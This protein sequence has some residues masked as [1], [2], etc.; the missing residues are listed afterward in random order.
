[1]KNRELFEMLNEGEHSG[2]RPLVISDKEDELISHERGYGEG[3]KPEDYLKEFKAFVE[4]NLNEIAALNIVCT[5]PKELTR[6]ALK[7]LKLELD[8]HH[9]TELQ[10]NSAWREWTNEDITAD[11]ISF[12]RREALGTP[13]ISHEERMKK[14]FAKLR[15]SYSFNK[16]Q[17][18]WIEK[19]ETFMMKESI[20]N[21]ETFEDGI[22]KT[23]GGFN[24][25]NKIFENQL[26]KI[27]ED[28]NGY[29]YDIA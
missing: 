6:E 9:F 15:K 16:I 13:L 21:K 29:L 2:G 20:F 19:I 1:M 7:S 24:S 23:Q 18:G 26:D 28:I 14:A 17:L 3:E 11:I 12:I 22:F 25:F 4:N 27:I 10:L 8:R 5:R